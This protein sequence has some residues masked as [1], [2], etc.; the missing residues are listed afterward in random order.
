MNRPAVVANDEFD[1]SGMQQ[2][3]AEKSFDGGDL[4]L[5]I[6]AAEVG[7]PRERPTGHHFLAGVDY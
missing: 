2:N 3:V 6:S 1:C 5:S 7:A 4:D